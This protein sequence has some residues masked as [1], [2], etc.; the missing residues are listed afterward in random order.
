MA[1]LGL[2]I[3]FGLAIF[4]LMLIVGKPLGDFAWGGRY[5]VLPKKLRIA[6]I[7]SIFLY[8]LFAL[9]LAS[10]TGII[11]IISS[12]PIINI[13][14][15]I[16]TT[17]FIFGVFMNAISRNKKERMMMTPVALCL[18]VIFCTISLDL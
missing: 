14:M 6:S 13:G 16:F 9:F 8:S 10:A 12:K 3:L 17:Y 1:L 2:L 15:W 7:F 18:A 11:E 5:K 4:Q